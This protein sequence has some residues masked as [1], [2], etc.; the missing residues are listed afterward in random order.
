MLFEQRKC[1]VSMLLALVATA[2]LFIGAADAEESEDHPLIPGLQIVST[3][4]A[5][6]DQNPYG[7]AYVP[8]G[9][10]Q[11]G[12]LSPG[13]LLVSNFNDS[14]NAQGSGTTIVKVAPGGQLST[15]FQGS[16]G[17]GLTLA[18]GVLKRGFVLV[19][20]VPTIDG[21]DMT[22]QQGSLL[23]INHMGVLK[24]TLT[25]P[26]LLDGPWGLTVN[27]EGA[28]AQIFVA[29]VLNGTIT[30]IDA[31]VS[32]SLTIKKM[33]MIANGYAHRLDPAAIVL[34]PSGLLFDSSRDVLYVASTADNEIFALPDAGTTSK[35]LGTG[36]VIYKDDAHLHGPL[37]LV[38]TP[39][40]H[41]LTSNGDAVNPD[42]THPS[43]IVE[44]TLDGHFV[45]QLQLDKGPDAGFGLALRASSEDIFS[46]AAVNDNNNTAEIFGLNFEHR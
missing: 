31:D 2:A 42:P 9:F 14:S 37:A 22:V 19:G 33:T 13:D 36:T 38:M 15:F 24:A 8:L 34:G 21:T 39:N 4:P 16:P 25:D 10:A 32:S 17:L 44:F 43:E 35:S 12:A 27:D 6:G 7:A 41:F 3:V 1:I 20:N 30:R 46:L 29:N 5:N 11:G 28:Q 45:Q 40:G 26:V 23:I 18:L